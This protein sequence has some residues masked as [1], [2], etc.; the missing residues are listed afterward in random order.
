LNFHHFALPAALALTLIVSPVAQAQTKKD[1]A[2]KVA[3]LQQPAIEGLAREIGR[4]TLQRVGSAAGQLVGN[5]PPD[6]REA[7]GKLMEADVKAFYGEVEARL[8][9]SATK[10]ALPAL[11][12]FL[13]EKF[14]EDELKQL[15]AWLDSP[16]AKKYAQLG[17]DIQGLLARTLVED[18]K[19]QIEPKL[20]VLEDTLKKRFIAAAPPAGAPPAGASPAGAAS[21][22]AAAAPAAA[23]AS[24]PAAKTK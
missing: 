5:L 13:E 15:A 19:P 24:K 10:A 14:T 18:T 22:P 6:K 3:Q 23:P 20:K 8:R 2:N 12:G 11:A 17:G 7:T 21:K 9:E 16:V 1:L 4:D